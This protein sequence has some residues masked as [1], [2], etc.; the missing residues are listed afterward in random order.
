[1][2]EIITFRPTPEVQEI[3]SRAKEEGANVSKYINNLILS[4]TEG[5]TSHTTLFSFYPEESRELYYNPEET[6]IPLAQAVSTY[7]VP[8]GTLSARRYRDFKIALY[9]C[10]MDLFH[11]K[12]DDDNGF[13]VIAVSREEATVEFGRY[14]IKDKETREYVRTMLPLPQIRYDINYNT[15]IVIRKEPEL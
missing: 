8:I 2:A 14:F 3:L 15:V 9:N 6:K 13:N 4:S 1:M 7:S 12:I 10:G 11:F 5:K